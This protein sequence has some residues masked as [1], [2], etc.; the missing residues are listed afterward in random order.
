M[1]RIHRANGPGPLLFAERAP[2]HG[3]TNGQLDLEFRVLGPLEAIRG[4][5]VLTLGSPKQRALLG[6]FLVH[7]NEPIP[8][9]RLIEELWGDAAPKTVNA[10]LNVYLSR[11]RRLLAEETGER[12]LLT[13]A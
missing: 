12:L 6:L 3:R 2:Y 9:E 10:V 4:E 13:E 1:T 8:R 5:R 11:L 7:A